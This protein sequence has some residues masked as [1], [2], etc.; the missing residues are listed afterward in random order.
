MDEKII[1]VFCLID[2]LL[3]IMDIQDDVRAK[4]SNSEILTIGYMGVRYFH[5]NYY[6]THQ[7]L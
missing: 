6:N 3:K 4:I 1:T 2:D 5:G 7:F